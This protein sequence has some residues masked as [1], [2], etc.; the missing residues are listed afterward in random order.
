[1]ITAG[2]R[3]G[4]AVIL[5]YVML[6]SLTDDRDLELLLTMKHSLS[7]T[8]SPPPAK[9]RGLNSRLDRMTKSMNVLHPSP[10]PRLH[11]NQSSSSPSSHGFPR[12]PGE[13]QGAAIGD[14]FSVLKHRRDSWAPD[15]TRR[16]V[17]LDSLPDW[18][19][20]TISTLDEAN[21]LRYLVPESFQE[22]QQAAH[23]SSDWAFNAHK[24]ATSSPNNH[25]T[26]SPDPAQAPYSSHLD[27]ITTPVS[28]SRDHREGGYSGSTRRTSSQFHSKQMADFDR[29]GRVPQ[30]NR[31]NSSSSGNVNSEEE[32]QIFAFNPAHNS[33][34]TTTVNHVQDESKSTRARRHHPLPLQPVTPKYSLT[35]DNLSLTPCQ[36]MPQKYTPVPPTRRRETASFQY[37]SNQAY[38]KPSDVYEVNDPPLAH[39]TYHYP[40]E[41]RSPRFSP[42]TNLNQPPPF[43][44]SH[45]SPAPEFQSS[46]DTSHSVPRYPLH[47]S[48][49]GTLKAPFDAD[50]DSTVENPRSFSP[51]VAERHSLPSS[52][53]HREA[54]PCADEFGPDHL[55]TRT[56]LVNLH[57]SVAGSPEYPTSS[58]SMSPLGSES[59]PTQAPDHPPLTFFTAGSAFSPAR[60]A[61]PEHLLGLVGSAGHHV[62]A[63]QLSFE[64][65]LDRS[66][67]PGPEGS[68]PPFSTPGPGRRVPIERTNTSA[69]IGATLGSPSGVDADGTASQSS[70][71]RRIPS[72][73][74]VD[75]ESLKEYLQAPDAFAF[76]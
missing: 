51:L 25:Y 2:G 73:L 54:V 26:Q 12:T 11:R 27:S 75:V 31:P 36:L 65:H 48:N 41:L 39:A 69:G 46:N 61:Q 19:S 57:R 52:P 35:P 44:R 74:P 24:Q 15:D 66:Y 8:A 4:I 21:P 29:A 20:A 13:A 60:S 64:S 28:Q 50:L 7:S 42:F 17:S 32:D 30:E 18:L 16:N 45:E 67:I 49:G 1:M 33:S 76:R 3:I 34:S 38:S 53:A 72:P 58:K 10:T 22:K 63:A 37:H 47:S 40:A 68:P 62:P 55:S 23:E 5:F 6:T 70:H 14:A 71:K 9:R 56:G 59:L 43:L